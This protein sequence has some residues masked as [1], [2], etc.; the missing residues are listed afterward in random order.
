MSTIKEL[1][2]EDFPPQLLEL[3]QAPKQL[4]YRGAPPPKE[5]IYLT[6]IGSRKYTSYGKAVCQE[7]LKGLEG[8]NIIIVSGLALGIDAIAHT[9][10]LDAGLM[11]LAMPG[12]GLGSSVLYPRTNVLLAQR[13]IQAGGT[14]LSEYD[15][16]MRA[17]IHTFPRRN[18][19]MAGIAHGTLIIEAKERSGTL[20]TARLA[21]EYNKDVFTVPGSILSEGSEGPHRLIKMGAI[22]VTS[23]ADILEHWGLKLK[24][25]DET[26]LKE[27]GDKE[28]ELLEYLS[29]PLSRERLVE[30]SGIS[31]SELNTLLSVLEIK[32]LIQETMGEIR[33]MGSTPSQ[34]TL[35]L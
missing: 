6:V 16:D 12:S 29:E 32:G 10:A 21:T 24:T 8:S 30:K 4:R 23:G 11:T 15:D 28:R 35:K 18:R 26:L 31:L 3:P 14:L 27:C 7:I 17:A 22:P 1:P 25:I 19:L 5:A 9:A 34:G 20:I 33:S 2:R 13:I